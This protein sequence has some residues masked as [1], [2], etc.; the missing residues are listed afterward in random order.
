MI[1]LIMGPPGVGKGTQAQR[2]CAAFH[3]AHLSTGDLLREQIKQGTPLGKQAQEHISA[4]TLVPD[5]VIINMMLQRLADLDGG[6]LLDGFPRTLQQAQALSA[7]GVA[8]QAVI[9]L[10]AQDATIVERLSGR[11]LHPAS[12]RTYHT[13]FSP[14]R[15]AGKDDQTGEPLI[16]RED[17]TPD[18]VRA[19]LKVYRE[20]TAPLKDYY[21]QAAADG[22]TAYLAADGEAAIDRVFTHLQQQLQALTQ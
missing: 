19:R 14:P 9:D 3:L 17:D 1:V 7:A 10:D 20:Q 18:T 13:T 11:L 5:E 4:G 6:A 16:Q 22:S 12:G 15:T 8:I 2:L 21:R